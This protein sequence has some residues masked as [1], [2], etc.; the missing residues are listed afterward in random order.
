MN[1]EFFFQELIARAIGGALAG[2]AIYVVI[3]FYI[4]AWNWMWT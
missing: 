2:F 3:K 4:L 1:D